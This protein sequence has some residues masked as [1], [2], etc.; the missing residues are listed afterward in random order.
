MQFSQ[1]SKKAKLGIIVYSLLG[2]MVAVFAF[3]LYQ[4]GQD[5]EALYKNGTRVEA[6]IT[7][8][9]EQ[10]SGVRRSKTNKYYM[11]VAFFTGV[12]PVKVKPKSEDIA[13][14]IAAISEEA[15]ANA[16][17]GDYQT[18][19]ISITGMEFVKYKQGD[20]V[21]VIYLKGQESEAHLVR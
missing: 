14:K 3:G 18:A 2:L 19:R 9:Y 21:T 10:V 4:S 16:K 12:A 15:I 6:S 13:D 1:L 17:L 20:K 11:E 7:G 5:S 8:L